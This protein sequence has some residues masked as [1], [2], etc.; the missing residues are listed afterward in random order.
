MILKIRPPRE[1]ILKLTLALISILI[2]SLFVGIWIIVNDNFELLLVYIGIFH[3][4]ISLL[5]FLLYLNQLEWYFIYSDRIEV[6][7]L[8]SVKNTV[9]F[10]KVLFVERVEIPLTSRG[11]YRTFFI[12]NDG[13]KN[14]GNILDSNS[15]YNQ[16][17]YNLRTYITPELEEYISKTLQNRMQRS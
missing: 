17:K 12:F 9:C 5:A 2:P 14:N 7:G 1:E 10:E 16:K 6:K 4:P 13:R 3:F 15:C 11:M 8:F